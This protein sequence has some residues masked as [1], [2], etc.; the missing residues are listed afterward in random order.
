M[1]L[2]GGNPVDDIAGTKNMKRAWI[3]GEEVPLG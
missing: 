2:V 3:A 1:V